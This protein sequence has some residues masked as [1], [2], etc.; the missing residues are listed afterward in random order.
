[1]KL[2]AVTEYDL[3][4]REKIESD[5]R[6]MAE[7]G[8]PNTKEQIRKAHFK[9]LE[10]VKAGTCWWFKI[11]PDSTEIAA[12]FIGIWRSSWKQASINEMGWMVLPEFQGRGLATQAGFE[13]LST[14]RAAQKFQI[15]HAFPGASNVASNKICE[16]LGF[17]KIEECDIG[18]QDRVL[19]ANHWQVKLF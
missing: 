12:G 3:D 10:S 11:M 15:V 1:M 2:L 13:L 4:L 19:R 9:A 17:A 18:Y 8:G 5:P 7:L 16:K 6:M 14:A